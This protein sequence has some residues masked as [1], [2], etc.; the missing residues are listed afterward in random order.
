MA[1]IW[2]S[3]QICTS[4][5]SQLSADY[6]PAP[7]GKSQPSMPGL[8]GPGLCHR[9][10]S[11]LICYKHI[12]CPIQ[13]C[14]RAKITACNTRRGMFQMIWTKDISLSLL[15]SY[16]TPS[17]IMSVCEV[18][19]WPTLPSDTHL[20]I[21][22]WLTVTN[23]RVSQVFYT[24]PLIARSTFYLLLN[25]NTVTLFRLSHCLKLAKLWKKG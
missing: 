23:F 6:D 13:A 17:R 14:A 16:A 2:A 20:A 5:T 24:Q 4:I 21:V 15:I 9:F 11:A 19:V 8:H 12:N 18:W 22:S 7:P 1:D 3:L 25:F 10:L